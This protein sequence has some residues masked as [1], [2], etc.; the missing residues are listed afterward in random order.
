M[1]AGN[2]AERAGSE[3]QRNFRVLRNDRIECRMIRIAVLRMAGHAATDA[4]GELT[5]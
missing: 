5:F 3:A 1:A 4:P 2:G